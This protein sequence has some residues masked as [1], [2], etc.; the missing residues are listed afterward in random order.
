VYNIRLTSA[1]QAAHYDGSGTSR[2]VY[3]VT[4]ISL[5]SHSRVGRIPI[6]RHT[7]LADRYIGCATIHKEFGKLP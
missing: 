4:L 3:I 1:T 2:H 6:E 7:C 5:M